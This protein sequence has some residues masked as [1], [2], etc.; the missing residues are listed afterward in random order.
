LGPNKGIHV[1]HVVID[2]LVQLGEESAQKYGK[3]ENE[4]L[5][6]A[7]IAETYWQLSQ[8]PVSC[9]TQETHVAAQGAFGSI[10]S[11]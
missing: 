10:A 1:F 2:G 6:P 3:A 8:Q 7:D 5:N 11:I 4:M 9:W